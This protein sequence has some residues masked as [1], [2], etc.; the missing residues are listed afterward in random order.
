M[1]RYNSCAIN[2]TD[3]RQNAPAKLF[4]DSAPVQAPFTMSSLCGQE[5]SVYGKCRLQTVF[6]FNIKNQGKC[7]FDKNK[8][9]SGYV[10]YLLQ[11]PLMTDGPDLETVNH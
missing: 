11:K 3:I 10:S 8:I 7:L 9:V 6:R 2:L 4:Y 5:N 1:I